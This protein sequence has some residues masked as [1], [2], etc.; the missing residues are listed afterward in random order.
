[1]NKRQKKKQIKM[2]NKKLIKKYPFLLPRNVWTGKVPKDYDYTYTEYGCLSK[3][4]KAGFGKFW[5]EDLR[6]ALI[7]TNFMDKFMF[8]ELKEKY[9]QFRQYCNGA[10]K[11]VHEVI[12][13]YEYISEYICYQCGSPYACVVN[14]YGWYLPL[15][16]DCWNKNNKKR[17]E[18]GYKIVSWDEVADE[19]CIGLPNEYKYTTYSKGEDI[20]TTVDISEI[21]NKILKKFHSRVK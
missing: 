7:K 16:K 21:T 10:P 17:A 5:L 11:E 12:R 8:M 20:V 6:E 19:S 15:C 3:G 1:M 13:K 14:D 2:R 18:K 9:G 4:W